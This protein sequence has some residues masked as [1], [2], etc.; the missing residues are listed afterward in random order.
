[1]ITEDLMFLLD[2]IMQSL[3]FKPYDVEHQSVTGPVGYRW[4]C[5][6]GS[7]YRNTAANL[8]TTTELANYR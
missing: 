4:K 2:D 7:G 6:I 8:K 5:S 3:V 1:M